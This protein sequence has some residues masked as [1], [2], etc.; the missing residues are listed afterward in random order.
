[1]HFLERRKH[2]THIQGTK[3]HT[4]T[5]VPRSCDKSGCMVDYISF[6]TGGYF[7]L[8]T[9]VN[10]TIFIIITIIIIIIIII[11][12]VIIMKS[13]ASLLGLTKSMY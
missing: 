2:L 5:S 8:C 11:I 12:I 9:S 3:H 10:K 13:G 6:P 4:L 7:L 1:M